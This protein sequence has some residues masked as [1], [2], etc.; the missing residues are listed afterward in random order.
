[1]SS[2]MVFDGTVNLGQLVEIV[3]F[4]GGA[5]L[6]LKHIIAKDATN[7]QVVVAHNR[8]VKADIGRV[9]LRLD[10]VDFELKKQTEILVRLGAQDARLSNLESQV[11][12]LVAQQ[13]SAHA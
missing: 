11:T 8:E 2:S 1:M 10:V 3:M 5:G 13:L 6:A 9:V 4:L 7:A 12:Q